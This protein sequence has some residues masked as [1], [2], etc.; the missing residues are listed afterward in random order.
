MISTGPPLVPRDALQNQRLTPV[1][2][3]LGGPR[4]R[5]GLHACRPR[6]GCLPSR[7]RHPC[8]VTNIPRARNR[9]GGVSRRSAATH[10]PPSLLQLRGGCTMTLGHHP[11]PPLALTIAW[12]VYHDV[13]PP[14]P[15]TSAAPRSRSRVGVPRRSATTHLRHHPPPSPLVLALAWGCHDGRPPTSPYPLALAI[16]WGVYSM[17]DGH[18]PPPPPLLT[19]RRRH[20]VRRRGRRQGG[21]RRR[22]DDADTGGDAPTRAHAATRA[23]TLAW[24]RHDARPPPTSPYTPR[25][26]LNP[27]PGTLALAIVWGCIPQCIACA[28]SQ[29]LIVSI[30]YVDICCSLV[31]FEKI[32]FDMHECV[33]HIKK[34]IL[35]S[36]LYLLLLFCALI[37]CA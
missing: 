17:T 13:R 31:D 7:P 6:L 29:L 25:A 10:H 8:H 15:P 24:E 18:H 2:L 16:A 12:G 9:V 37:L 28:L 27:T 4:H 23:L 32:I 33:N 35:W 26:R 30:C 3:A 36:K 34:N 14:P 11:P 5:L 20:G 21:G 19:P 1:T 22:R